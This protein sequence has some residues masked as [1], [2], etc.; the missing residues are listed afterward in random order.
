MIGRCLAEDQATL[1]VCFIIDVINGKALRSLLKIVIGNVFIVHVNR[2]IMANHVC[3][4][5]MAEWT[6]V[7]TLAA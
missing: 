5:S 4:Y 3:Y 1:G 7:S 2:Q 6:T